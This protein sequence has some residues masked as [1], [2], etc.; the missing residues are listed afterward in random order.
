MKQLVSAWATFVKHGKPVIPVPGVDWPLYTSDNPKLLYLQPNNYTV[1]P[2]PHREA[3]KLWKPLLY[4]KN[5]ENAQPAAPPF[6]PKTKEKLESQQGH[7]GH[8]G[9]SSRKYLGRLN[10]TEDEE[11]F[12]KE[13]V[14]AWTAFA[15]TGKPVI[16]APGVDWP[17]HTVDNPRLL[18]MQPNN[19]T[20]A[21]D[22]L[23]EACKLWMPLLYR[24]ISE[25]VQHAAP[26][27]SPKTQ[28][29]PKS[30]Q[31]PSSHLESAASS[32]HS[33]LALVLLTQFTVSVVR[34]FYG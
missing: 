7:S 27:S 34:K 26:P 4:R 8:L 30:K 6:T 28:E 17:L 18:L 10:Y 33:L 23:R 14:S 20:I 16:P 13:L 15:K 11:R 31:V 29:S 5:L 1:A 12:M 9:E 24:K 3:C 25:N 21:P 22:Q 32:V 19:Y 2:D